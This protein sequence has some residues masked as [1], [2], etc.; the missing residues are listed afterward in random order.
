MCNCDMAD[1]PSAFRS[2]VRTARKTHRCVECRREITQGDRYEF[3]SGVW[4]GS[5]SSF[6]TCLRCVLLRAAHVKADEAVQAEEFERRGHRGWVEPCRPAFG[7]VIAT[8]GECARDGR[9]YIG[10]IRRARRELAAHPVVAALLAGEGASGG[11][12]QP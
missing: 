6:K 3:A 1:S 10:H 12:E 4:D 7:E 2:T 5:P 9:S 11:E 8:I